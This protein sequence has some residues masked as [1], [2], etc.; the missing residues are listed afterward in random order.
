MKK[1]VILRSCNIISLV[2]CFAQN[3]SRSVTPSFHSSSMTYMHS[4]TYESKERYEG[5]L[6]SSKINA[7]SPYLFVVALAPVA[8]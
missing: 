2:Y 7:D 1:L 6:I 3:D 4:A 8:A 5:M